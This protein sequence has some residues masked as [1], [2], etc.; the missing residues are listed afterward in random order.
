MSATVIRMLFPFLSWLRGYRL[1]DL[2]F[3]AAS[4]LTV[5][6]VLVPQSMANAQLAGLPAWHG[7][8][9]AVLKAYRWQY[10]GSGVQEPRFQQVLGSLID[11]AQAGR[12]AQALAPIVA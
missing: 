4:G 12:I 6:L 2:K 8:Y 7:L 9:A 3:D 1:G 5:A 10:I 11:D